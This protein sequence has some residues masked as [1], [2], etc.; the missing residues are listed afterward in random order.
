MWQV[1]PV[2]CS[3]V[4][5]RGLTIRG[6]GGPNTD[7]CD[8]ESCTDVLIRDCSFDT[9]DDCIAIKA[10]RNADGRRLH[11]PTRNVV[12]QDCRMK[13]GHGGIT[14]GSEITGGVRN[15]FAENCRLDSPHLDIAVRFKN[16]AMRGG[17]LENIH[18][19]K[20]EIGQVAQ[21][22]V[23]VDFLYEEGPNGKFTPVLRNVSISELRARQAKYALYLRGFEQA[24]IEDIAVRDCDFSA[25]ENANVVEHVRRLSLRNVKINGQV[26]ERAG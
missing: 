8:P 7:G 1:H 25:V 19:R 11:A 14:I 18:V 5:V 3:N 23:A 16:N 6:T 26:V 24:V 4:T 12:I 17:V 22:A 2:L 15:V 20:L 9:G 10:G 21:A 13:D